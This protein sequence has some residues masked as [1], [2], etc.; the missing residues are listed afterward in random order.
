[1]SRNLRLGL[2]LFALLGACGQKDLQTLADE[3]ATSTRLSYKDC[4]QVKS[5]SC[6][7]WQPGVAERQVIA[8]LLDA[9]ASCQPARAWLTQPT[10]E[11][12]PIKTV[13][14]VE[15]GGTDLCQAVVFTDTTEDDF[16]PQQL[17]KR[18]C[19]SLKANPACGNWPVEGSCGS[20]EVL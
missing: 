16:G 13:V 14:F 20:P 8:C 5:Q 12:D 3:H 4:G 6:S 19:S 15:T 11:G 10:V 7:T 17:T 18:T 1:M 2:P 9:W